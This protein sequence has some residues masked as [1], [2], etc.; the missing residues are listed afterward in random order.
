MV[1]ARQKQ[2]TLIQRLDLYDRTTVV[3]AN[4]QGRLRLAV[5][6]VDAPHI[7][8]AGQLIFGRKIAAKATGMSEQ[9]VRTIIKRLERRGRLEPEEAAEAARMRAWL[10]RREP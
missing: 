4:P 1:E 7:G 2:E 5:I 3:I 8:V 6:D 10:E 9:N